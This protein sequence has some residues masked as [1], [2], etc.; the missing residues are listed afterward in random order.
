[1]AAGANGNPLGM[2]LSKIKLTVQI[3]RIGQDGRE[4]IDLLFSVMHGEPLPLPGKNGRNSVGKPPRPSPELRVKAAEMLLD[5]ALGRTKET[6]ELVGREL[7]GRAQETAHRAAQTTDERGARP[8]VAIGDAM[9]RCLLHTDATASLWGSS[10]EM[11]SAVRSRCMGL[12]P[13]TMPR[14]SS[15]SARSRSSMLSGY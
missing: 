3:R 5:R 4:L 7:A 11:R 12:S 8:L 1:M 13:A 9:E 10:T 14:C 6:I 2:G 15:S